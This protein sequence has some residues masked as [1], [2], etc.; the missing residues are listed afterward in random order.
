MKNNI[1][2]V[3]KIA[4]GS[5]IAILIAYFMNLQYAVAAGVIALLSIED[6]KKATLQLAIKRMLA[7]I[8][9]CIISYVV[10]SILSFTPLAYGVYLLIF[11]FFCIFLKMQDALAMNAVLATHYLL[12]QTMGWEMIKNEALLLLVGAGIGILLNLY[13]PNNVKQIRKK[14]RSIEE[15]LK[16]SLNE[17]AQRIEQTAKIE[18]P[19]ACKITLKSNIKE[20][21]EQAY[22]NMNNSFFQES[23]YFIQYMEMR[24]LQSNLLKDMYEKAD[25]LT[26]V[27]M[28]AHAIADFIRVVEDT[29]SESN[30][31]ERLIV[32]VN[33]LI[34]KFQ[35]DQLPV[36]REEFETRAILYVLLMNFKMFLTIKK[37]FV[38]YLSKEQK[39]KYWNID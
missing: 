34:E 19:K 32:E 4:I 17:L 15:C 33:S 29:L 21:M 13:I 31:T 11:S 16:A 7:F 39:E 27:T 6:T 38:D 23:R 14:Q 9:T 26:L 8:V 3:I 20:G 24:K 18:E 28:Q 25:T 1:I 35:N 22:V 10:F 36:T 30:N 2:K 12:Q 5:T 37:E